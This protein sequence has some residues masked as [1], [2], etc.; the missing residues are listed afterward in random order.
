MQAL[1]MTNGSMIPRRVSATLAMALI[2][3]LTGWVGLTPKASAHLQWQTDIWQGFDRCGS[4]TVSQLQ[5]FWGV[6][7]GTFTQYYT[8]G[9][10]IG[11]A[12]ARAPSVSC[13]I[14]S[15]SWVSQVSAIG[16]GLVFIW[17]GLQ[18]PCSSN[19]NRF[20]S[21]T[22]TA[23]NQGK[24]EAQAAY[25]T[26]TNLGAD[27]CCSI[28][29]VDIEGNYTD[30]TSCH[31]AINSFL[32][33]WA[34]KLG[35]L[36]EHSG[37]YSSSSKAIKGLL[38]DPGKCTSSTGHCPDN[39]WNAHYVTSTDPEYN[40]VWSDPNVSDGAWG[41][42]HQRLHQFKNGH[43]HTF[44]GATLNP[45]DDDCNCGDVAGGS[46]HSPVDDGGLSP[47]QAHPLC[48]GNG[49]THL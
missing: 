32:K 2:L 46:S 17:D 41:T 18:A 11:G 5:K 23:Y 7:G 21:N 35:S 25:D 33:G 24:T 10:Y 28:E 30:T 20:S 42:Y 6:S 49:S 15:A 13:F 8:V 37:V 14:P 12:T 48:N 9:V 22:T 47:K 45:V 39:V 1:S 26:V 16:Y 40:S 43:S 31:A 34:D 29:Y 44:N 36:S 3:V 19:T 4:M 38:T 27:E